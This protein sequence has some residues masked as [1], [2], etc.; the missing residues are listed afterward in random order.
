MDGPSQVYQEARPKERQL[1]LWQ[2]DLIMALGLW[3]A[4]EKFSEASRCRH[5]VATLTKEVYKDRLEKNG[6]ENKLTRATQRRKPLSNSMSSHR[7]SATLKITRNI[8]KR[9]STR[10]KNIR[11][12][13]KVA[14]I[15]LPI[16]G[17]NGISRSERKWHMPAN[18]VNA[19]YDHNKTNCLPSSILQA[20][21]AFTNLS[22]AN[23]GGIGAVIARNLPPLTPMVLP[24]TS[25]VAWKTGGSQRLRNTARTQ[26]SSMF[27]RAETLTVL[28]LTGNWP[29]LKAVAD[30]GGIAAALEA[31]E[32][33]SAQEGVSFH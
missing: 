30:L 4:G 18:M 10:A 7:I 25:T 27:E 16:L 3:Y 1:W 26:R 22:S 21:F 29:F 15:T 11:K 24:L 14:Q 31:E 19:Y 28:R 32:D 33:F 23:Y 6:A 12:Y 13:L 5:K 8:H 9:S 20:P 17:A 2:K